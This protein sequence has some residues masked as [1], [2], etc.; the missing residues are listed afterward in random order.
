MEVPTKIHAPIYQLSYIYIFVTAVP[1]CGIHT[2]I[3]THR[4]KTL[5]LLNTEWAPL[6]QA[7]RPHPPHSRP[8]Q[9]RSQK[10]LIIKW[11][12]QSTI[13]NSSS[14][15]SNVDK[16]P[17]CW[18]Y[19]NLQHFKNGMAKPFYTQNI[20]Y[21]VR[22]A[23]YID[24]LKMQMSEKKKRIVLTQHTAFTIQA[25]SKLLSTYHREMS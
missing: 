18:L 22:L 11:A 15:N 7:P 10:K 6:S 20:W 14:S 17:Y 9:N 4:K 8:F 19:K 24:A 1:Q 25:G 12:S 13:T 3:Q 5:D 16:I 2:H 21:F 23:K